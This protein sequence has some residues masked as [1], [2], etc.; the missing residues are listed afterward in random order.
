M[1]HG[2]SLVCSPGNFTK[3]LPQRQALCHGWLQDGFISIINPL[4]VQ[5]YKALFWNAIKLAGKHF[6]VHIAMQ[7]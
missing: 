4:Y 5:I 3:R 1:E 2:T 6:F 7:E